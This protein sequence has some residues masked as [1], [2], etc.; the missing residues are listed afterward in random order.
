MFV[1][2]LQVVGGLA[3]V[4]F[5]AFTVAFRTK[6]PPFQDAIRR[7][8]RSVTNPRVLATAGQPGAPASVVHHVGRRSGTSYRTPVVVVPADEGFAVALPY[9]PG[10]DWVRNVLSAG[11]A[12]IE[13]EGARIPI[14]DPE[15]VPADVANPWFPRTEQLMHRVYG[16]DDFL[17]VRPADAS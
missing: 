16:V 1:R 2:I 15:L 3:G 8:N 7:M 10:A 4:L 17:R 6:F 11:S 14:T 9:G 12:T 13:H 5:V